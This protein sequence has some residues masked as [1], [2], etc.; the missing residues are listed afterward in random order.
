MKIGIFGGAF[1]PVHN[2]HV[3]LLNNYLDTLSL[4]K[5]LLIPTANPP[6]KNSDGLISGE[7][8][9]NMLN[10]AFSND[11]RFDVLDIEFKLEGK[12]YTYNTLIELKKL[13]PDDEFY[14]IIGS[15]QFFYFHN[16]Y[17]AEDILNMVTVVTASREDNEYNEMLVYKESNPNM[18]NAIISSV[19]A[20]KVSSSQIR[21][22]LKNDEN[23]SQLVPDSVNEY[24]R[25]NNLYV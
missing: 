13:Y 22:M 4:D 9:I 2:G 15:D 21:E 19:E 3:H 10:L 18:K 17:R 1:N 12:S 23:I 14:L 24:I 5:V 25:K 11:Y 16:W 7:H 6:H 20:V 8:R